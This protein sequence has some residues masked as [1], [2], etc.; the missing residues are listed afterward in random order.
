MLRRTAITDYL[1][2]NP[3]EPQ[4][5]YLERASLLIREGGLVAFPTETVYGLGA[6]ALDPEAVQ[7]IYL[8]KGR[9]VDNPLIVHIADWASLESLTTEISEVAR[10]LGERFWPGP[11]TLV[12]PRHPQVPLEVTAGLETVAIRWPKHPVAE[13]L[14]RAAGVPIAAPSANR[15]GRPSPTEASHVMEDLVGR[16]ELILDGGPVGLGVESTVL[17]LTKAVP[18]ILRPGGITQEQLQAVLPEVRLGSAS[19][20]ETV[21]A[22]APESAAAPSP[23]MQYGHYAPEK[24]LILVEGEIEDIRGQIL[25]TMEQLRTNGAKVGV[26][27]SLE[28]YPLYKEASPPPDYLQVMGSR[29]DLAD[30]AL[31]LFKTLRECDLVDVD[32]FLVEGFPEHGLGLAIMDRLRRACRGQIIKPQ[33]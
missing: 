28:S 10:L 21:P 17:D 16:I 15:S 13:A 9:P 32:V 19:A 20:A 2:V 23:G 27:A 18:T 29:H 25:K 8:A 6:N 12:L 3:I 26:L 24:P 22:S 5:E 4:A 1:I 11:L 30:L 14:I 33:A 31:Y 7:Q